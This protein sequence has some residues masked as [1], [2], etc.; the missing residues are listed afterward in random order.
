MIVNE[1]SLT[2]V[3]VILGAKLVFQ[4]QLVMLKYTCLVKLRVSSVRAFNRLIILQYMLGQW[5][6]VRDICLDE[7]KVYKWINKVSH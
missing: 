5:H 3:G 1:Q 6:C 7:S 4:P 2:S